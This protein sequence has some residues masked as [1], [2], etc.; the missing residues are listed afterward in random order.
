VSDSSFTSHLPALA[1]GI[2]GTIASAVGASFLPLGIAGTTLGL[3]AGSAIFG[4]TAWYIERATRHAAELARARARAV[5][6]RGRPLTDHETQ[7]IAVQVRQRERRRGVHW[8][9][10][11]AL[12]GGALMASA[13]VM[14]G[15]SLAAGQPV[16]SIV[17]PPPAH[18]ASPPPSLTPAPTATVT[19]PSPTPTPTVTSPPPSASPSPSPSV[20]SP[21]P[22]SPGLSPSVT[23][24]SPVPS[25]PPAQPGQAPS[26]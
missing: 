7:V 2:A 16:S 11:A 18:H 24:T 23:V 1:G 5:R 9:I 20:T 22:T 10:P 26:Y 21:S 17:G 25:S 15:W 8:R 19:S 4:V 12:A 3:A 6:L 14:T 13:A